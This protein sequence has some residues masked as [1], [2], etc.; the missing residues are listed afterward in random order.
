MI[1]EPGLACRGT[2]TLLPLVAAL[3]LA[4]CGSVIGKDF[5]EPGR[6]DFNFRHPGCPPPS[7]KPAESIEVR[8][9][10]SGGVYIAWG[11][12]AIL[13]GPYFSHAGNVVRAL[14]G[15]VRFDEKRIR[16]GMDGIDGSAVLAILVGHSHFDHIGD[17]PVVAKDYTPDACVYANDAGTKMLAAY[18]EIV[19]R[20]YEGKRDEWIPIR[21]RDGGESTIRF[22]P[23]RSAHAPQLCRRDGWPCR[24]AVC[25]VDAPWT[26]KWN[27]R[28]LRD[29]CSGETHAFVIDLLDPDRE[30]VRYRIYYNDSPARAGVGVPPPLDDRHPYDLAI[31]CMATFNH[32]DGYPEALLDALQPRH[33]LISHYDDFFAKQSGQ[34]QFVP[35]LSN[36]RAN[37]FM[38]RMRKTL[39][40]TP[41]QASPPI[42][43]V[44]GPQTALWSMPVP[45]WRLFFMP[46]TERS[47]P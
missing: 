27:E 19:V 30:Q 40:K 8:Y 31:L 7:S 47:S 25:G 42:G 29:L 16:E 39:A 11:S 13:V 17:V 32:V 20:S 10:G 21:R 12:D 15:N 34:W 18:P 23:V 5:L 4:G 33:V 28:N 35:L 22:M 24:Y 9:L 38:S 41:Q 3:L 44:C 14:V 43:A 46:A 45:H 1:G 26:T 36:R 2:R 6:S 37:E